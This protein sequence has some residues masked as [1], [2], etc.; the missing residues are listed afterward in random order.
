MGISHKLKFWGSL[1][2]EKNPAGTG[3]RKTEVFGG[4]SD[5]F[6]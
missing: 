3:P 1:E 2:F 6:R 5:D 4:F